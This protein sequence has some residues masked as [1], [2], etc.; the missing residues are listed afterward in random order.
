VV[1]APAGG[2]LRLLDAFD[3]TLLQVSA[4]KFAVSSWMTTTSLGDERTVILPST[5]GVLE[6]DHQLAPGAELALADSFRS[7]CAHPFTDGYRDFVA[8]G[9]P[10]ERVHVLDIGRGIVVALAD[11][12]RDSDKEVN[13]LVTVQVGLRRVLFAAGD[14]RD[15]VAYEL[16]E[17][18]LPSA[19]DPAILPRLWD[20]IKHEDSV[21]ALAVLPTDPPVLASAGHDEYIRLTRL[22]PAD[23]S[24]SNDRR[25]A[26]RLIFSPMPDIERPHGGHQV[27]AL[28]VMGSLLLS[29]PLDAPIREMVAIDDAV[30]VATDLGTVGLRL[31]PMSRLSLGERAPQVGPSTL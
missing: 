7:T 20:E 13:A 12:R 21:S 31:S 11:R 19:G 16:P 15:I 18:G 23:P 27:R 9:G 5:D 1:S 2:Q 26:R 17:H 8:I 22:R 10:N 30:V 3:G 4:D 25:R 28:A 6:L 14:S 24:A 29:V